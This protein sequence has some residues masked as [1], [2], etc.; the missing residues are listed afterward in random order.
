MKV[1]GNKVISQAELDSHIYKLVNQMWEVRI[2]YLH[3]LPRQEIE[4]F[5]IAST[6]DERTDEQQAMRPV[7]TYLKIPKIKE[8]LDQNVDVILVKPDDAIKI[9]DIVMGYFNDR[10]ELINKDFVGRYEDEDG[11]RLI[12][13][14]IEDIESYE[15]FLKIIDKRRKVRLKALNRTGKDEL[16]LF[17]NSVSIFSLGFEKPK[18]DPFNIMVSDTPPNEDDQK[19]F[20][21]LLTKSANERVSRWQ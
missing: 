13:K 17:M 16:Q 2:P 12:V 19:R 7:T 11:R 10:A 1:L 20:R 6:G 18:D 14:I 3:S 9:Y 15:P 4:Y 21:D 5:G 8:L